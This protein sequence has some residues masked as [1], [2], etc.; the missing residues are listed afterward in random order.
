VRR[1]ALAAALAL[2][3]GAMAVAGCAQERAMVVRASAAGESSAPCV[4]EVEGRR[5]AMRDFPAFA[6]RWRGREA[7]LEGDINTPYRC[8][9]GLIYELQRAGFRRIGFISEPAPRPDR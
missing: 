6:R 4:A 1:R 3:G 2:L 5:I 8:I 9:G 7:H